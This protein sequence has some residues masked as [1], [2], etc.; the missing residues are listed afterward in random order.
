MIQIAKLLIND[1]LITQEQYESAYLEFMKIGGTIGYHL[2]TQG[3]ISS[4]NLIDT[5]S[6]KFNI[7]RKD[8]THLDKIDP[9]TIKFIS[10]YVCRKFRVLPIAL[11]DGT[12]LLGVTDPYQLRMPVTMTRV[13]GCKVQKGLLMWTL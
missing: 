9:E 10:H 12:L 8:R 2:V 1:G 4:D 11:Q 7:V 6:K 5:L 3:A 13:L